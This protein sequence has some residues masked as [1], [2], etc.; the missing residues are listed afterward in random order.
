MT[1]GILI[2][3]KPGDW[4]S[5]DVVAKTRRLAQTRKVGHAGTLDPMATGVL[6]L[7]VGRATRLLGHLAS[8]DKEYLATIRLGLDTTTDD[9]E[10]EP[11]TR[12]DASGL[13]AADVETAIAP[14]RGPIEQVPSAVSAIK[15]D[16]KRSYARVR[17][18]EDVDLPARPVTVYA[19][20]L[21]D[22][23]PAPEGLLDVDVRVVCSAGTYIRALARD[24]GRDLGVG[25]HLTALRRIRSGGFRIE[26]AAT[27]DEL[28][29]EFTATPLA[30]AAR[31]SFPSFVV[32][33]D[34]ATR[35]RHGRSVE[36]DG[37]GADPFAVF[38]QEGEFLALYRAV[39]PFIKPVAVFT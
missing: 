32:D 8:S 15:I 39:G 9:A 31:A 18:G 12:A 26:D 17:D 2:V 36:A 34:V 16:G 4:T 28:A 7:G 21:G 14:Y 33:D 19:F 22:V 37:P 27:L 38:T 30:E 1:D 35:V 3:D 29:R 20:D 10:G 5:H 25:G 6:V 13:N 11:L 24:V 23:R